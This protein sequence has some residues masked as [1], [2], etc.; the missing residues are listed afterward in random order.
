MIGIKIVSHRVR[1]LYSNIKPVNQN[2]VT[3]SCNILRLCVHGAM[4]VN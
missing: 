2:G 3:Q 4:H 1:S